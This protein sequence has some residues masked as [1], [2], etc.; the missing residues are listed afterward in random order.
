MPAVFDSTRS[1]SFARKINLAS[2]F[3]AALFRRTGWKWCFRWY[4]IT[5]RPNYSPP[6]PPVL[7]C[8]T[9][10]I[11]GKCFLRLP[12]ADSPHC[13]GC[14]AGVGDLHEVTCDYEQCPACG[15]Q[16][17]S[18]PCEHPANSPLAL[19]KAYIHELFPFLKESR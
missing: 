8:E 17:N 2:R 9:Y 11:E 1:L 10:V 16:A 7:R 14:G 3:F 13:L 6:K 19:E 15:G 12:N 4:G 5:S 18:C